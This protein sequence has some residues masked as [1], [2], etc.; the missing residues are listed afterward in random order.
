M[1]QRRASTVDL[2]F[3]LGQCPPTQQTVRGL[4]WPKRLRS[5]LSPALRWH[6]PSQ[7]PLRQ[8]FLPELV[9]ARED[10]PSAIAFG[11]FMQQ[12]GRLIGPTIAGLL[13]ATWNEAACFLVNA[14]SK[15][16]VITAVAV[17]HVPARSHHARAKKMGSAFAE[18]LRYAWQTVPVRILL[19]TLAACST[20]ALILMFGLSLYAAS[21][22]AC[23]FCGW[24][25]TT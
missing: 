6:F 1:L 8:T 11:A 9:P 21:T 25:S 13:L 15:L 5:S 7:A 10:L 3:D 16:A 20:A 14:I 24:P 19:P 12:S 23:A 22:F 17:M 18:G 2:P 4:S